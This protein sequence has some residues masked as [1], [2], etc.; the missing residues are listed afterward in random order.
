LSRKVV[1]NV[2]VTQGVFAE[3]RKAKGLPAPG[4]R[5]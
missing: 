2:R 5:P 4:Q 1:D 3:V